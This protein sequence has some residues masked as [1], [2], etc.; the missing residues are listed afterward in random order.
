MKHVVG[1]ATGLADA[2]QTR[3][4]S[5]A[6]LKVVWDRGRNTA[7]MTA[8]LLVTYSLSQGLSTCE[9]LSMLVN[10]QMLSAFCRSYV[11][12]GLLSNSAVRYYYK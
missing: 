6:K 1:L 9:I 7:L 5:V 8:K 11:E 2:R 4:G 12:L 10:T 3:T